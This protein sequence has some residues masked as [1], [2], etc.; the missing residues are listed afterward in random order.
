MTS[1]MMIIMVLPVTLVIC[2]LIAFGDKRE[3]WYIPGLISIPFFVWCIV[4]LLNPVELPKKITEETVYIVDNKATTKYLADLN[5]LTG[6]QF[7]ENDKVYRIEYSSAWSC[8][9][10]WVPNNRVI[11]SVDKPE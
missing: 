7:K 9:F 5:R 1:P 8:G 2:S 3:N 4:G 10:Y 6:R 11:Y